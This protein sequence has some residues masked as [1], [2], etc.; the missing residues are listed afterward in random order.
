[1]AKKEISVKKIL[2]KLIRGDKR[3]IIDFFMT[4]VE[5]PGWRMLKAK[6]R[7]ERNDTRISIYIWEPEDAPGKRMKMEVIETPSMEDVGDSTKKVLDF[8]MSAHLMAPGGE[9]GVELGDGSFLNPA[10]LQEG[11]VVDFLTFTRS[12]VTYKLNSIGE[13]PMSALDFA[14]GFDAMMDRATDRSTPENPFQ[15]TFDAVDG[16]LQP[17]ERTELRY[18]RND[19]ENGRSWWGII[20]NTAHCRLYR[21]AGKV[22]FE[23]GRPGNVD[24]LLVNF[25]PVRARSVEKLTIRVRLR[26][27]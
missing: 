25:D 1:M 2:R 13:V 21:E 23:A 15:L 16:R 27:E 6:Q 9:N 17:G 5:V 4:G 19:P 22:Y 14:R 11:E 7:P 10:R 12:N 8:I 18:G 24:L 20:A 26:G 3:L